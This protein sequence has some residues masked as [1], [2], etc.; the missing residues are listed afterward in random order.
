[1][2]KEYLFIFFS[3]SFMPNRK[4]KGVKERKGR[5]EGRKEKKRKKK[6]LF[7]SVLGKK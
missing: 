1:M 4:T 5:S 7:L 6:Q 2:S 3:K